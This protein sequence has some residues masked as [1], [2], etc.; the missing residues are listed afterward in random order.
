MSFVVAS[1]AAAPCALAAPLS[2]FA[3]GPYLQGL[4]SHGVVVRAEVDPPAALSVHVEADARAFDVRD[5]TPAAMHSVAIEGLAPRTTYRFTATSGA[6]KSSGS[7]TTAPPDDDVAPVTFLIYGDN[8]TDAIRHGAVVRAMVDEPADLLIHTGDFVD[9]G[10]NASNWQSFFDVE[11]PLLRE[12]CLFSAV[13]NHELTEAQGASW[14]RFFGTARAQAERSLNDTVRWGMVRFFFINGWGSLASGADRAWLDRALK[15][16]DGEEGVAWRFLVTHHGPYSSGLHGGNERF[17]AGEVEPLLRAHGVSM[18]ISGHDHVYER[19]ASGMLRY[20][21]SGGGGAPL[22]PL[23]PPLPQTR[24]AASI[25][26]YVR[27]T[28][29]PT[30]ISLVVKRPDATQF[31]SAS[32]SASSDRAWDDDAAQ[33]PEKTAPS[34]APTVSSPPRASPSPTSCR[35]SVPGS[36]VRGRVP[37]VAALL[38]IGIGFARRRLRVA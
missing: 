20:V 5:D 29:T 24:R 16:S 15:A 3:K 4:S 32:F 31:E 27:V 28:V 33:V 17:Q 21:V 2:P 6:A 19:G 13:G 22:Y 35:C 1:L 7:F 23:G 30:K 25:Y 12:R 26:H 36:P 34:P 8:R 10:G 9:D 38:L 18:V 37:P 11:A 14:L